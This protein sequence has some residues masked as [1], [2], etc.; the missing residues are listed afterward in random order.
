MKKNAVI[1]A[2]GKSSNFAPFT[3]EKPKGIFCV[4]GEILIERQIKQ[5][6]E[7]GVE[8]IHVVVGYM[9]EKFFYL[10]EKYGVH[11]IVNNTF[12]EKGNL[13]SLYVAWEY[14]ANTYICCAD[15]YFVDN[16]FIEE[17][18]LNYSYRACTFYQ[19]KFREFGVAYSDAMVITDVSVGGMDQ[20]AMVG[21]AY[22][23]ESFSAKFR[24]Y[25]EQEIDRFRV[26]DMFWE[27]FYAKHLKELSLYVKE[28]DNRSILEFEGIEDLR[29]FD[30][31]FLLNVDSD[32]ISNICSVLKCNPNEINEIDVIN[33]GLTNVS[34]G[35]KVNGQGYV[36]RHP[37]GTAGNLIDRQTELFAQ[38]AAYEIGIDKSVIYMDISGW[39]LS[40]YVPKAVYCD[41]EASESQLS[42]AMEYLHKLHLVKPDPAV[43]I[44]DNVAEGKKLMQIASL[45]K[46]NLFREFQ[47]IIV[48]V[49]KLYAAIQ[50]DAKRLGYERV[51]CHNDTYAPNYLCS[52]TQEVY[53][54]DWEYAGLNYAANDIGCILCRYDWS[55][56]QIER[57]LKAYIGRPMNQDERRFYYAFIPISAFYWFCWGLYKGSVGDDDSFFF[58][59]SYRNLIRFIDKAMESYGIM[60]A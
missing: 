3:Y 14:L 48:K 18:P 30:S 21:H 36:Y 40:H 6:L 47:E 38:N 8:E 26:A 5:L 2:A 28:F 46:G 41:F 52:D 55:D 17:N 9:K 13:Y 19:G 23:N 49:D 1:L 44:F 39:K 60:G 29:Q 51:L 56:Q 57:Y 12:A 16:P 53:L 32:I 22:F 10:E 43:K 42:T 54:I 34:F 7:A 27:E 59:P 25:M 24:N 58:L 33:A 45:T 35:F 31:E 4:K 11:L 15:H 37:G 50:E 20:M